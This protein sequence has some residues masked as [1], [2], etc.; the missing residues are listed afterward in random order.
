MTK[1]DRY[2]YNL[3]WNKRMDKES[4]SLIDTIKNAAKGLIGNYVISNKV[5]IKINAVGKNVEK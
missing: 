2:Q 1:I 5:Q 3:T 4:E